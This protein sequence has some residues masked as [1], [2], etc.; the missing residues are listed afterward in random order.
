MSGHKST[1]LS[2]FQSRNVTFQ[3]LL[4]ALDELATGI[5]SYL[6]NVCSMLEHETGKLKY[7]EC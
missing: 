5:F 1:F 4:N 2:S 6:S 7:K 3:Q